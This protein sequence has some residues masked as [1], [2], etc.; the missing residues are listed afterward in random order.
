MPITYDISQDYLY[1][2]GIE[3]AKSKY[4]EQGIEQGIERE[5]KIVVK[6]LIINTDFDDDKIALISGATIALIQKVRKE[7]NR[8]K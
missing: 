3:Y 5:K 4:L 2:K 6:N 1:N 7:L 8:K